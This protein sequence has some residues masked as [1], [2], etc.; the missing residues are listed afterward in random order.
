MNWPYEDKGDGSSRSNGDQRS[1]GDYLS[2]NKFDLVINL[3]MS[4]GGCRRAS[5]FV[6]QGYRTRRMAVDYSVPLITDVKC[7]KLFIEVS[8]RGGSRIFV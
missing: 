6:T 7:A 2:E 1:I 3:P 8:S 5:S 4:V